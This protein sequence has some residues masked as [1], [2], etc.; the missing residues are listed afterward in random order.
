MLASG[1]LDSQ[2]LLWEV[3]GENK[4]YLLQGHKDG[5]TQICWP[6]EDRLYSSSADKTVAIWDTNRGQRVRKYAE[7]TGIINCLS[8]ASESPNVFVSGG[9]DKS[10]V[11]YDSRSKHAVHTLPH[12]Y[13][14]LSTAISSDGRMAYSAGIDGVIRRWDLRRDEPEVSMSLQGHRDPITG[15]CLSPDGNFLLS[16]SMDNLLGQ[17]DLK[18]FF[19]GQTRCIRTYQGFKHGAEKCLLRCSWSYDQTMVACGSADR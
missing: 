9:D 2:I 17:W 11:V 7:H 1:S 3:Y 6:V 12:E 15:I 10:V 5:V 4:N 8:V 19:E 14:I 16:N 13:Q 18:P